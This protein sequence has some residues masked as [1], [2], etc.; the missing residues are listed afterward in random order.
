MA[1]A[2]ALS[3]KGAAERMAALPPEVMK[4]ARAELP[5]LI[6]ELKAA[7][8]VVIRRDTAAIEVADGGWYSLVL[9][10]GAWKAAD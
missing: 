6:K 8:R 7:K 10:N 5:G 9:E 3:T 4:Q 1:A 2:A